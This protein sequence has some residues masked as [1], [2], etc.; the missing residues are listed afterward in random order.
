MLLELALSDS[1]QPEPASPP[2]PSLLNITS[3]SGTQPRFPE[4][5]KAIGYR[6]LV[7]DDNRDAATTLAMLL[8]LKGHEVHARYSGRAGIE[9]IESLQPEIVLLDIGMPE[10][11]GY[12]TCRLI[13][14]QLWGRDRIVIALTGY[15]QDE[16]RRR[17]QEA[18][19]SAHLVKPMDIAMLTQ[20]LSELLPR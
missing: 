12:Q 5:E 9:A 17:S 3:S 15:G 4:L 7:V 10:L 8:Q 13:R 1:I 6:I 11:D 2:R 19:F 16:D 18:G 14:Q 20:L